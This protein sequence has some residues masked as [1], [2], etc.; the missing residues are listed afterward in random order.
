EISV[1]LVIVGPDGVRTVE[2]SVHADQLLVI[3]QPA[4]AGDAPKKENANAKPLLTRVDTKI[5]YAHIE[6]GFNDFKRQPLL[7]TMLTN[8]GPVMAT[9]DVN[10]DGLD[11]VYVGGAQ[12]NPGR[13]YFQTPTGSFVESKQFFLSYDGRKFSAAD[14]DFIDVDTDDVVD[15]YL[16]SDEYN[17]CIAVDRQL[18]HKLFF[19]NGKVN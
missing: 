19:Y 3:T 2:R 16:V 17:D 18:Q 10:G 6:Y 7:L 12:D 13:L 11:D 4:E 14:A 9:G 8:C 15:V 5:P 1:P